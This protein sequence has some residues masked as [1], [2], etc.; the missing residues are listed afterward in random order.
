MKITNK[1]NLPE[2]IVALAKKDDYTKGEADY[3]VTEII[4]PPRIQLLRRKHYKELEQDVADMLWQLM[5]TCLHRMAERVEVKDHTS[6][7]RLFVEV[8]GVVLS[9]AMDLQREDDTGIH[10][11]DYKFTSVWSVMN[12]KPDWEAQQNIYAWMVQQV[13][14]QPVRSIKI[15][16]ILRDWSRRDAQNKEGYPPSQMHMVDIP[17]WDMEVTEA[18][19]RKRIELHRNAKVNADWDE[20]LPPCSDMDRWMRETKYAVKRE[21]RKTA[22][23]VFDS[24]D[25]ATTLAEVEKGYVEIRKGES[26]RCTGNFCGVN[27]WCSQYKKELENEFSN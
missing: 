18:Y 17:I 20:E 7:E 15:G 25:E 21:G 2:T 8:D 23:R 11:V 19:I 27:Q 12:D 5:G 1:Y 10:I 22:I 26:V 3:S 9:G 24:E 4:S 13:K 16:A 6:E 14:K